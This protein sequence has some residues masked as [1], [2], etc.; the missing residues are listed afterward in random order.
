MI[1]ICHSRKDEAM[2]SQLVSWLNADSFN[3]WY[4]NFDISKPL[5]L[6]IENAVQSSQIFLLCL[7]SNVIPLDGS[8]MKAKEIKYALKKFEKDKQFKFLTLL[9]GDFPEEI[10]LQIGFSV[11]V[12]E[13]ITRIRVMDF[14]KVNFEPMLGNFRQVPEYAELS[15]ILRQW[16]KF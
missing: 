16:D 14:R 15:K 8:S 2:V 4:N 7:T 12:L 1:F 5:D 9:L 6:M 11:D 13:F 10:K 3:I